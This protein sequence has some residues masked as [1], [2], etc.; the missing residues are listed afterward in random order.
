MKKRVIV[1]KVICDLCGND[2]SLKCEICGKDICQNCA[3]YICKKNESYSVTPWSASNSPFE[4]LYTPE[5]VVC[6]E[7]IDALKLSLRVS[8]GKSIVSREKRLPHRETREV[9]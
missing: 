4:S 9:V 3:R 7:C 2:A 5:M 6:K 1:E 8:V